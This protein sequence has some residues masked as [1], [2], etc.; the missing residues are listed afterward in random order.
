M[1]FSE[2]NNDY[3]NLEDGTLIDSGK[4]YFLFT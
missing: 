1:A 4:P 2:S 3:P